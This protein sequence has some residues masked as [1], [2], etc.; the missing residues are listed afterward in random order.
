MSIEALSDP[1]NPTCKKCG[2]RVIV[3]LNRAWCVKRYGDGGCGSDFVRRDGR[4]KALKIH[5]PPVSGSPS[6][7]MQEIE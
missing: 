7:Y 5:T 1:D 2:G 4:W 3:V 6:V